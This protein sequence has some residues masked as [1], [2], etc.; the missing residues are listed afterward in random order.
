MAALGRFKTSGKE[1]IPRTGGVLILSNHRSDC[2][3]VAVQVACPR[4]IRFMAKSELWNMRGIRTVLKW[5]KAF[6]VKRG[7]PDK[8][9][10]KH[11]VDLL[12]VGECVCVF[13]EGQLTET[14]ELQELKPG[15]A[16]IVRM[17]GMPVICIGLQNTDGIVP[18]RALVPRPSLKRVRANWGEPRTFERHAETEEILGWVEGELRR[19]TDC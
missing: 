11:A 1:H 17:S 18:Y 4:P 16:L 19:L 2:D 3:P 8:S 10:I 12:K 15:V 7:E 6:P 9:A 5:I 13:P 14:G